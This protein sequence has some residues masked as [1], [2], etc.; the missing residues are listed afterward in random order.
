MLES[1]HLEDIRYGNV[2]DEVNLIMAKLILSEAN[3]ASQYQE[4]QH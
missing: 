2:L 3:H 1:F 4:Q